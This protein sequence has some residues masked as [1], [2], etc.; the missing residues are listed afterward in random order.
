[1]AV[2]WERRL[3]LRKRD[4]SHLHQRAVRHDMA[5]RWWN[6]CLFERGVSYILLVGLVSIVKGHS[7]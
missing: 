5:W 2:I 3:L 4:C 1:V 7:Y 6:R